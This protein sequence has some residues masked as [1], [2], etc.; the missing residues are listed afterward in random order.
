MDD[1]DMNMVADDETHMNSNLKGNEDQLK[2]CLTTL[3]QYHLRIQSDGR[4]Q[5][6][7]NAMT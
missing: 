6:S 1:D 4:L 3:S 2:E 7:K 5:T